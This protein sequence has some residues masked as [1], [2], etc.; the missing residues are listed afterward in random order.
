MKI[1][2]T[3]ET[4][5]LGADT[6]T[7]GL[8]Q[9]KLHSRHPDQ[10]R[11]IQLGL[12]LV[13]M[14]GRILAQFSTLI[15]PSGWS[16]I[17][18]KAYE[19]HGI[20]KEDCE[21]FG[22]DL[23][24]AFAVFKM[25]AKRANVIVAHNSAFDQP[26][27]EIEADNL[28]DEMPPLPW[29]CTMMQAKDICRIPPTANMKKYGFK[30]YKNPNLTEALKIICNKDLEGAH[31]AMVDVSGCLDVFLALNGIEKPAT[32]NEAGLL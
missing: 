10:A 18:P 21:N 20:T 14:Q 17:H 2:F 9:K 28:D 25:F 4:I 5:I 1:T 12:K 31:D 3:P 7:T 26:M 23:K 6:E 24:A 29:H 8:H 32:Q 15:K 30:D 16:E 11:V 19:A 22:I 27:M 13:N